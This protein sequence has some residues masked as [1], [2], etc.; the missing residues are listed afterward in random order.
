MPSPLSSSWRMEVSRAWTKT[1]PSGLGGAGGRLSCLAA[2]RRLGRRAIFG[3]LVERS[4]R[5][6]R[7]HLRRVNTFAALSINGMNERSCDHKNPT[8]IPRNSSSMIY[9]RHVM[10]P[11]TFTSP[12]A[13]AKPVSASRPGVV[14][15]C[16]LEPMTTHPR[17]RQLPELVGV[18]PGESGTNVKST[19]RSSA[20]TGPV[21]LVERY[22]ST[23]RDR[24]RGDREATSSAMQR[25]ALE[26]GAQNDGPSRGAP[27]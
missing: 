24:Q 11:T 16:P 27:T 14:S 25:R 9:R 13:V 8:F 2:F 20:A 21:Q 17:F 10:F 3:K 5:A 7:R 6:K 15:P 18:R 26:T 4:P 22:R 19:R 23:R 1:R 12:D